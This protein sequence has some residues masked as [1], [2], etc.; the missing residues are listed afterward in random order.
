MTNHSNS[1]S[2]DTSLDNFPLVENTTPHKS[3]Y[4]HPK[5]GIITTNST[6]IAINK[7]VTNSVTPNNSSR[8]IVH[9]PSL[10]RKAKIDFDSDSSTSLPRPPSVSKGVCK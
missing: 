6:T 2:R 4:Q 1:L 8:V 7:G 3:A 10:P 5:D 9:H